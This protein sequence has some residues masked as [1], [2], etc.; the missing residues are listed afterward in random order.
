MKSLATAVC[1]GEGERDAFAHVR[2]AVVVTVRPGAGRNLTKVAWREVKPKRSSDSHKSV[3]PSPKQW[4]SFR[5]TPL[6]YFVQRG[7]GAK[8]P[9]SISRNSPAEH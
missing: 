7:E 8:K 4:H 5:R 9:N 2:V 3:N 1:D 6:S